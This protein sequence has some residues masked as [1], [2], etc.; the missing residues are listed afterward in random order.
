MN[1]GPWTSLVLALLLIAVGTA[2]YWY[3]QRPPRTLAPAIAEQPAQPPEPMQPQIEYPVPSADAAPDAPPLPTLDDSDAALRDALAEA[4]GTAPVESLLVPE[5]VIRNFVATVDSLDRDP[6]RLRLRPLRP[7]GDTL[8]VAPDGSR[9]LL[10]PR[11]AERYQPY[12]DVLAAAD[13][14]RLV[15]LY[16]R[17][18]PL[19]QNAYEELGYPGRWFN[20]RLVAILDHLIAT[21]EVTG[22]IELV[23]A[24]GGYAFA[25]ASLEDLSW[26]RKALIRMSPDQAAAVKQKLREMRSAI[27]VK[28]GRAQ[29]PSA[30][31]P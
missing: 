8:A 17:W 11:N 1:K 6:V 26:G 13:A 14:E 2:Y 28:A 27:V 3:K 9:L 10:S 30:P 7:V 18:Y 22:P 19:F 5:R 12:V 23:R 15:A 4:L 25:D 21:P 16:L 29:S 24:K 31:A 20:D